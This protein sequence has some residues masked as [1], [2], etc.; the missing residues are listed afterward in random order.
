MGAKAGRGRWEAIGHRVVLDEGLAKCQ[1]AG[2]EPWHKHTPF[3]A[4]GAG[5]C[6]GAPWGLGGSRRGLG[7]SS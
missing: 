2:K 7:W 3:L 6:E 5:M 4:E 1:V